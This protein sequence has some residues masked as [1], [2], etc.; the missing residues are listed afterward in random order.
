MVLLGARSIRS[1]GNW[2]KFRQYDTNGGST[3]TFA[4]TRDHDK[5]NTLT[6]ITTD[7]GS[8]A[9]NTPP[10]HDQAGN[11]TTVPQPAALANAYTCTYDAWNRLVEVTGGSTTVTNVYDGLHRRVKK[12]ETISGNTSSRDY[13]YSDAWQVLE[14][15]VPSLGGP[16]VN[17]QFIWG[18][19]YIDD[20]IRRDRDTN[21]DGTLDETLFAV[22]DGN[23]NVTAVTNSSGAVAVTNLNRNRWAGFSR[24]KPHREFESGGTC[25]GGY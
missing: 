3:W 18:L 15:R 23:F 2:R 24:R 20:L 10:G 17:R 7:S 6:G 14:E 9:F 16:I 4:Q 13:Y 22:Q 8:P 25:G 11:M 5:A 21:G 19:R 1:I 12:S